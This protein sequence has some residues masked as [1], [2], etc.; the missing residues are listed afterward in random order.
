MSSALALRPVEYHDG[1]LGI[2]PRRSFEKWMEKRLGYSR[3]WGNEARLL[4]LNL[5]DLLF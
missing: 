4:A 1:A 3:A 5:R 2:A